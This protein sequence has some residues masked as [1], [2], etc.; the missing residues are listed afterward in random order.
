MT[1]FAPDFAG[2]DVRVSPNFGPRREGKKPDCLVLHYTGMETGEAAEKWLCSTE[3]EVSAHYLV[4]EDGRVVQM[5]READRAW[6]AGQGSW[7]G[8]SDVN[9]FSIGIEIVNPGPLTGYPEFADVQMDAVARLCAD[10]C[11]RWNIR[12]ERVLAHSDV[13]PGRK[14]DP[15]ERFPWAWLAEQGIGHLVAP[16][17]VRGGR[18]LAM[19]ESGQPVEALQSMLSIYGY[20]LEISGMFDQQTRDVVEAFQ[21]HFRPARVDGVADQSTIETLHRLLTTLEAPVS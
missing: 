20:G 16:A 5:V 14:T 15:G 17:P 21:R 2:A 3:S 8:M 11:E 18:F 4:H 9:S 10:I 19:G 1:G 6:H 12:P 13:A 7:R